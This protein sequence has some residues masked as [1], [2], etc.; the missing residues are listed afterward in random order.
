MANQLAKSAPRKTKIQFDN[1]FKESFNAMIDI[2]SQSIDKLN[3]ISSGKTI[4]SEYGVCSCCYKLRYITPNDI[5]TY[6][7][8][9]VKALDNGLFH[10]RFADAEMF[11][12]ASVKRFIEA[13]GCEPFESSSVLDDANRY[14]N[15]KNQTLHDLALICENDIGNVAVYSMGEMTK[16][17]KLM[18]DDVKKLND[19]HFAANMKKIVNSLPG[20]LENSECYA[21][22]NPMYRMTLIQFIEE[23][24]L[25]AC[26]INTIAVLQLIGYGHPSVEY[27]VK[28]KDENS[29]DLITE[30]C[31]IKTNDF[32]IRNKIPFNC[33]MKDVILQDVTPNFKDTH[34]ALHFIMKDGRSPISTLVNRFATKEADPITDCA[35]VGRLFL[36]VKHPNHNDGERW[37]TKIGDG[38]IDD[39]ERVNG[40]EHDITWLDTIAF[41][42]N[43]LDGNYRRD[44]V[45]NNHSHP[46]LNT[47]DT[48]YKIFGGCDLKTNEDVA[49]NV[50]RVACLIRSIIHEYNNGNVE[51]YDSTKDLLVVLGEIFTRNMLRLFYNNTRVYAYDD[52]MPDAATPGFICM[53]SFIMEDGET[54]KPGNSQNNNNA[55]KTTVTFSNQQGQQVKSNT[56]MKVS[57]MIQK[58]IQWVRNSLSKFSE[59]FNKNHKKE[60]EWVK[61]NMQLNKEIGDA[62]GK[63]T[64]NPNVT[65]FPKFNIPGKELIKPKMYDLVQQFV[66]PAKTPN[67]NIDEFSKK[68]SGIDDTNL[69]KI[70]DTKDTN[71]LSEAFS[72][73]VLFGS[74]E[75]PKLHT[76]KMDA[77]MWSE[78][79]NDLINTPDTI[80]KITKAVSEDLTKTSD[81]LQKRIQQLEMA[82]ADAEKNAPILQRCN[83]LNK[84]VQQSSK[85]FKTQML[86]ILNSKFYSTSYTIYREIVTGYKQQNNTQTTNPNEAVQNPDT[87]AS[88][89]TAENNAVQQ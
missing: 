27:T 59:N 22:E 10:D 35:L 44:A 57:A 3:K 71:A 31:L 30:C 11:T 39:T 80:S 56:N 6:V 47:L 78:L 70:K 26:T 79:Y 81:F 69:A 41:G 60:V 40:F 76:G 21:I 38:C 84:A 15:P 88:D 12:V 13:N 7:S 36:G 16:R 20:I 55:T 9:L 64:F 74:I 32:I 50:V 43:F 45:G 29:E 85:M 89:T 73:Y 54:Q 87:S 5:S 33:N 67:F 51:N 49:N 82:T 62:I 77:Q 19:M 52:T 75:K 34:D 58:F 25:F 83:D 68:T 61:N 42:N 28:P 14:V 72:N 66:D 1:P 86:N 63:G 17:I 37:Y 53:E 23:L 24:I 8:N 4:K 2:Y 48:V 46:I 18:G 65:N